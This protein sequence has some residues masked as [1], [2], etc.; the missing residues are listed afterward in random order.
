MAENNE[1]VILAAIAAAGPNT[2][3]GWSRRV[4]ENATEIQLMLDERS[5]VNTRLNTLK[6]CDKPFVATILGGAIEQSST[7]AIVRL[8]TTMDHDVEAIRTERTD[9]ADGRAMLEK[10]KAAKGK[11]V[12]IWKFVDEPSPGRKV[13]VLWHM[14]ILGDPREGEPTLENSGHLQP[15]EKVSR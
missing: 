11:R 2:G 15:P 9:S 3:H 12:R 7:R 10:V 1:A 8:R 5:R 4:E 14:Q 6:A 13:R